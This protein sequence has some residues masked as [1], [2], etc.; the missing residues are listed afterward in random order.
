MTLGIA[1]C[2][3]PVPSLD[4]INKADIDPMTKTIN[5]GNVSS[6]INPLD[7]NALEAAIQLKEKFDA[8]V[9]VISMT[10]PSCK[11]NLLEALALGAD[12]AYMLSD[13]KFTGSDTFATSYILACALRHIG[14][15]D[16]IITGAYSSD[17]G[18]AQVPAQLAEW[19]NIPHLHNVCE[20]NYT[21]KGFQIKT[22]TDKGY[23]Q[24]EAVCPLLI[25]VERRLNKPRY[26]TLRGIK[27][28]KGKEIKMLTY[29]DLP[30]GKDFVGLDGS[31][32]KPGKMHQFSA[33]RCGKKFSGDHK[34]LVNIIIDKLV[35]AGV[36]I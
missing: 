29:A 34:T 6:I 28:A 14:N 5:R 32:T 27:T 8:K 10:P 12:T 17:G 35:Q 36:Q 1:V 25:S 33:E 24:W 7:R 23:C 30:F 26:A 11:I 20:L 19:L 9:T 4:S 13:K 22:A 15:W 18:T 16:L 3:K 21:G 2:V 31:P